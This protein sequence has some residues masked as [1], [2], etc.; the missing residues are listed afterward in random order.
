MAVV[1]KQKLGKMSVIVPAAFINSLAIGTMS[2][3]LLFVV[4][5]LY[6]ASPALV[7]FLGA[8]WSSSYF[9]G[10][11]ILRRTVSRFKPRTAMFIMT[12]GSALIWTSF[13]LAPGL[14]QAYVAFCL[15]GLITAFFWPPLMGWLS[16]GLEGTELNRA[17][18]RFSL[19]WSIGG[20]FSAYIAGI[21]S[22]HGK[23]LPI[24]LSTSLFAINAVLILTS[25][26]FV[27]ED[28]VIASDDPE[29]VESVDRST[30]LR[31]PAWLGAFLIYAVL[32]VLFNVFPV[33]ARDRL[34]QSESTIGF[35]LTMRALATA[36][37]FLVLGRLTFWQFKRYTLPALSMITALVLV[38]L[39]FQRSGMGFAL[40]F[41]LLGFL[42]SGMYNNSLFY[43]TSG[44][45][46]RNKRASVHEALVTFGQV[47]GSISG[48]L[49]Y[50][51][52]SMTAVFLGLVLL[53][54]L[55]ALAQAVMIYRPG[56]L[57]RRE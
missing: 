52:F 37:G 40:C 53:V 4:K 28:K 39:I 15:Y 7:G 2:L 11:I 50:Q 51:A 27:A 6:S 29:V 10:C 38:V 5:D 23:F 43:A 45:L 46:D 13:L 18:S 44:A 30:M 54:L 16:T 34:A 3:G 41:G 19:S 55:G 1:V 32:G 17:T 49:L 21:L 12:S 24:L 36:L 14:W 33:F 25:N 26:L 42:Q 22:E 31:F 57:A 47:V 35:M 8:L 48:A 56:R 20:V 9:V